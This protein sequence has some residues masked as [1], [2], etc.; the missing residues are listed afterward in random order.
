MKT[1][2]NFDKIN[3]KRFTTRTGNEYKFSLQDGESEILWIFR[4]PDNTNYCLAFIIDWEKELYEIK[5]AKNG[6][7]KN[8]VD[9]IHQG[10]FTSQPM[11]TMSSFVDW[12]HNRVLQFE[13]FYN[14]L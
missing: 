2:T 11:K 3:F 4:Q 8:W 10:N 9:V 6:D 13:Y 5:R 12:V 14:K 1:P 7:G